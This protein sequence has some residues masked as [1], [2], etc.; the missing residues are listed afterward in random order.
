[1]RL[2]IFALLASACVTK[3]TT[4]I[5]TSTICTDA[6]NDGQC[7]ATPITLGGSS[8]GLWIPEPGGNEWYPPNWKLAGRDGACHD[9]V[10]CAAAA[11]CAASKDGIVSDRGQPP[12]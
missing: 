2:L 5:A 11:L 4:G 1:M 10:T 8:G 9:S 12:C 6:N 3:S 7:D